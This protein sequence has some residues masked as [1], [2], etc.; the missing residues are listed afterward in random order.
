MFDKIIDEDLL[1]EDNLSETQE[2]NID[3]IDDN[4]I[5]KLGIF[6]DIEWDEVK[7]AYYEDIDE[8]D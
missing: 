6:D 3:E 5:C 2:E 7:G 8:I 1:N 4:Y